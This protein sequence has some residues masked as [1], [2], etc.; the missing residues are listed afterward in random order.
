MSWQ[1]EFFFIVSNNCVSGFFGR[2][3]TF[4]PLWTAQWRLRLWH[5]FAPSVLLLVVLLVLQ[6][7]N[8]A[9]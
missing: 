3:K 5:L 1:K 2:F 6:K 4:D 7:Q 9:E 8:K